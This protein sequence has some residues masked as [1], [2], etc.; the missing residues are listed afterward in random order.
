[1]PS[2][3]PRIQALWILLLAAVSALS[4]AADAVTAKPAPAQLMQTLDAKWQIQPLLQVGQSV[5]GYRM[6]G[7]PDGLGAWRDAQGVLH[8]LM[9][10]ELASDA[11]V[12]RQH[13]ANGAF[14]SH[15][16]LELAVPQQADI[17]VIQGQDLI[18]QVY[19]WQGQ[20]HQRHLHYHF[21]RLCSADLPAPGA[22]Y[23]PVSQMG[24]PYP[25][26]LN[27]EEDRAGGRAFVHVAGGP[28][29]GQSYEFAHMG[30]S[31]WENIVLNPKPQRK[32]IAI[33]TDDSPGGQVYLYVGN[34]SHEGN[35]L[36]MAG[37]QGG[38]LY[39]LK[40]AGERFSWHAFGDVS[41]W[42]GAQLEQAGQQAGVANLMRPEDG[43]WDPQHPERFYFATTD[44]IDGSS[45]LFQLQ[46]DDISAPEKGGRIRVILN[47]RD[48]QAQMFDNITVTSDGKLLIEE[49]PG[50]HPHQAAIW[51]VDPETQQAIKV[52]AVSAAAFRQLSSQDFLTQ[53]EENSGIIEI[54]DLLTHA[55]WYVAGRHYFLSTLQ[56]HAPVADSEL[57]QGGQLYLLQQDP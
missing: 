42:S 34:K 49:D 36:Q 35:P 50:D 16:Q 4:W 43:A 27:G 6:V 55:P 32:T 1:M 26:F 10:H 5:A 56:I 46:F 11:G 29:M 8:V 18:Q 47:A 21:N 45:Q 7:V 12:A 51:H 54:T 3:A 52:A 39:G 57:V 40:L 25:L 20:Q 48:I 33:G 41:N 13:G 30:K 31:A 2:S 24:Y 23:D 9:N 17:R 19:L 37:L 15:W 53:D 22:R 44:K 28:L 14:V 38:Q